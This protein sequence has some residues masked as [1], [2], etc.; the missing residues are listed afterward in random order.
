[1]PYCTVDDLI[2][3]FG[4]AE[5]VQLT[6][7][8]CS[9][10]YEQGTVDKALARA[11]STINRYLAG[12]SNLPVADGMVKDF[13][14]DIARYFLYKNDVPDLVRQRYEAAIRWLEQLAQGKITLADTAGAIAPSVGN[15]TMVSGGNRFGRDEY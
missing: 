11:D 3:E 8:D 15:A 7:V 6:D 2:A 10:V 5:L 1:M 9:G 13:A 4:V 12:L 14:C